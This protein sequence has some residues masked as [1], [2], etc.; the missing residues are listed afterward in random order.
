VS[1]TTSVPKR[2]AC[3]RKISISSGP[4]CRRGSRDSS[5]PRS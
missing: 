4:G 5:R 3:S 1:R 2:R